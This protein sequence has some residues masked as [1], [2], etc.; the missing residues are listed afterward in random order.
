M[1]PFPFFTNNF[2]VN[3]GNEQEKENGKEL[4]TN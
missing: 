3:D 1:I 2:S 4:R